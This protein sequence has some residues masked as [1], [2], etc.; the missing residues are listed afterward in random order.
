MRMGI[1]GS[2]LPLSGLNAYLRAIRLSSGRRSSG[3]KRNRDSLDQHAKL[4]S[5][6]GP[7]HAG[8]SFIRQSQTHCGDGEHL[9]RASHSLC[10]GPRNKR[11]FMVGGS[12]TS[13]RCHDRGG[14]AGCTN[15]QNKTLQGDYH[16]LARVYCLVVWNSSSVIFLFH[17]GGTVAHFLRGT[18]CD[19][20]DSY[21]A[22]A[23]DPTGG[24]FLICDGPVSF[25]RAPRR[26]CHVT[27]PNPVR[28][29]LGRTCLR[30]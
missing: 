4:S 30:R 5:K 15:R 22:S 9:L 26:P 2:R 28:R 13:D 1:A 21:R 18:W 25:C 6:M 14:I 16:C 3:I 11:L 20:F 24:Q 17:A 29:A 8:A 10:P 19:R 12:W 7:A 23:A 27:Q